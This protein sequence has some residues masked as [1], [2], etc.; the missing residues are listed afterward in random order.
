MLDIYGTRD[1]S[2]I[3]SYH[4]YSVSPYLLKS[5][6][7]INSLDDILSLK[8]KTA[9]FLWEMDNIIS[10]QNIL[11]QERATS[12]ALGLFMGLEP[13]S[14]L[15]SKLPVENILSNFT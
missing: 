12:H 7:I 9:T 15:D 3:E 2:S 13:A 1:F 5:R 4:A 14:F 6:N 11:A 8:I 10:A